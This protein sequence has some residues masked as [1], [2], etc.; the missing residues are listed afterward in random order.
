[1]RAEH[2]KFGWYV[3]HM[4]SK[5]LLGFIIGYIALWLEV[6]IMSL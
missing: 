5:V 6:N 1:M 4:T 3:K 2:V